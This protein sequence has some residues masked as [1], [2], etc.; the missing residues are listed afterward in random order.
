MQLRTGHVKLDWGKL[1]QSNSFAAEEEPITDSK[2]PSDL[3]TT[4]TGHKN[5]D[6]TCL[7]SV[8]NRSYS[9]NNS[10]FILNEVQYFNIHISKER[11]LNKVN[12]Q[13]KSEAN[14]FSRRICRLRY[15]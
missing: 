10:L 9:N 2:V 12:L 7:F 1:T 5:L 8:V 11:R 3:L 4:E 13:H 6:F 15:S 14:K